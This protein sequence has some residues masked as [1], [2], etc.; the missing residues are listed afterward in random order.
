MTETLWKIGNLLVVLWM[1]G[2]NGDIKDRCISQEKNKNTFSLNTSKDVVR[3]VS[4]CTQEVMKT[5]IRNQVIDL[6]RINVEAK[7]IQTDT[8]LVAINT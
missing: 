4:L 8:Y 7:L 6:T 1:W 2:A 3:T 5:G